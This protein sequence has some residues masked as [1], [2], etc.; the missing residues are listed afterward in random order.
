MTDPE[1]RDRLAVLLDE[2]AVEFPG[3]RVIP[4]ETARSQRVIHKLIAVV[5]LGGNR[6]Y[7]DGYHTT[8]GR[9]I[10]V[11]G[12][13]EAMA[14]DRRWLLLRHERVHMRQFR[15][16]TFAGMTLLYLLIPLPLG[17]AYFRAR[18]EKEAYAETIRGSAEL[19]GADHVRSPEFR[20]DIIGEFTG[21]GYGWMWPFRRAMERW[22][23]RVLAQLV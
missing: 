4:K 9:R 22:Y 17:L 6:S 14:R 11:T 12:G 2:M 10:Y 23:D 3:F 13:W 7:L 8:I 16:F 20:Q 19:Y 21:P 15:R 5:T 1:V 18:F